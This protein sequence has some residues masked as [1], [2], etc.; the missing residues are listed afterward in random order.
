[1]SSVFGARANASILRVCLQTAVAVGEIDAERAAI[2]DGRISD[3]EEYSQALKS[4]LALARYVNEKYESDPEAY[5]EEL[6][7]T[8]QLAELAERN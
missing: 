3:A 6:R 8:R 1:M 2:L 4:S 7:Q 5:L